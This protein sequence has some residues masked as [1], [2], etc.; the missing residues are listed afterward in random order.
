MGVVGVDG[1]GKGRLVVGEFPLVVGVEL[2]AKL[3]ARCARGQK[4]AELWRAVERRPRP[5]CE[6]EREARD[7]SLLLR[8]R[9]VKDSKHSRTAASKWC[10]ASWWAPGGT[11]R[12]E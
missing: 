9:R 10:R 5:D 8:E 6:V 1:A 3:V 11:R 12:K 7:H 2:P 4:A